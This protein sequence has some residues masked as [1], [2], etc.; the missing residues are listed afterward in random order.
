MKKRSFSIDS[1]LRGFLFLLLLL[2][3]C[4]LLVTGFVLYRQRAIISKLEG[5]LATLRSATIPLR[6][7]VL[8]R[9]DQAI[10]A[11]FRFYDADGKEIAAFERSWN[12][13]E[14]SID[15]VLVPL[16][17]SYL[18][19]PSRV[20]TDAIAPR[21]GTDLFQ[22]YDIEGFP[23]IY[24]STKL[25]SATKKALST[26]FAQVRS[27]ERYD[28]TEAAPKGSFGNAVHDL[29]RLRG[30]EVGAIYSLLV[31]TNGGIEIIRD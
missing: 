22:Y 24:N 11:R 12:G 31:R 15:S 14:L 18:V 25:D 27:S 17:S 21:R 8:S 10:S 26:L 2:V 1:F 6:F 9:S 4:T 16:G 7:M 3:A 13:S 23:A 30:F 20:F 19:F 29:K 28:E 5:R